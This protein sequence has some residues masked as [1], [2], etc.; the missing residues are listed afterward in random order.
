MVHCVQPDPEIWAPAGEPVDPPR[1]PQEHPSASPGPKFGAARAK[2]P[3]P[4]AQFVA[5]Q[6][7]DSG[8]I[9]LQ[10]NAEYGDNWSRVGAIMDILFP[11]GIDLDT[12]ADHDKYH[13][14]SLAIVKLTRYS[15]NYH[16]GH[17]DSLKDCANYLM[18]VLALDKGIK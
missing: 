2:E 14:F 17:E 9:F 1:M 6:L 11:D 12:K 13:L 10:R 16:E 18:M 8:E 15:H 3:T 5:A 7:A 4:M